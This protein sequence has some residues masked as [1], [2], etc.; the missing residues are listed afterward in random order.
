MVFVGVT[1]LYAGVLS[2]ADHLYV[3]VGM[4]IGG[5]ALIVI[6]LWKA[7]FRSR[8]LSGG[9]TRY[10]AKTGQRKKKRHLEVVKREEEQHPA[11]H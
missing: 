11:Y 5:S 3:G 2:L 8:N 4:M 6:T 7:F 1:L 9:G 10:A